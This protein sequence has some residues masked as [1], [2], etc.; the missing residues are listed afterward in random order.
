MSE[1]SAKKKPV[2]PRRIWPYLLA[3]A[4]LAGCCLLTCIVIL[5]LRV[6]L[7]RSEASAAATTTP[8]DARAVLTIAADGCGVTRTEVEGSTPVRS[9]T[10]VISDA[11]GF[12]VLERNAEGEYNYRY[13]RGGQY[14]VLLKA[15]YS[16]RYFP[17]SNEVEINC[18]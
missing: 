17:V 11:E 16:D 4:A 13:F 1:A 18:P 14:R 5:L 15:W 9:L 12:S 10:W 8:P 2:Q 3:V 6:V 7:V